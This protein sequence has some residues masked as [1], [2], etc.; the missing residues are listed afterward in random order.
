MQMKKINSIKFKNF[1]A[2]YDEATIQLDGKNLLVYGENGSGK[3]SIFWAL[4]TFLQ[5]SGKVQKDI[6]KYFVDFDDNNA[7]TFDSLKNIFATSAQD[8]FIELQTVNYVL[9]A[10]SGKYETGPIVTDRINALNTTTDR[11]KNNQAISLANASSDFINYKLLHNFYNVTHKQEINLWQVF[12]RDIF[13]LFRNNEKEKYYSERIED[14]IKTP[15]KSSG[16]AKN[17]KLGSRP[18]VAYVQRID[19]LNADIQNFLVEIEQNANVFLKTHFFDDEDVLR[20]FLTYNVKIDYNS[21]KYQDQAK[22]SISLDLELWDAISNSWRKVKRPHSFLNEAQLTRVAIA[23]RIGALQTRLQNREYQILCLDDML[24]SLDMGNRDKVIQ[25]FLNT[26]KQADLNFFDKFQKLIFT[27]DKAFYNLCKQRIRLSLDEKDW[28]FK[29]IYLDTD[30]V[31]HRPFIDNS[32]DYFQR[33]EKHSKA[34]D[35]P[36][37]ANALRQGLENLLFNFLPDND[38]L[39]LSQ[40]E[41]TTTGKQFNELL[42]R[43]KNIHKEYNVSTGIVD[44]LFVYKDHLL[45]PFSHDNLYT[46]VYKQEIESLLLIVPT[47][48]ILNS[49]LIKEAKDK[50]SIIKLID[51]N[52]A[53]E[54]IEYHIYLKENL[55][56]HTLLDGNKYLSKCEVIVLKEV[57][58]SGA[59]SPLNNVY[60]NLRKCAMRLATFLGKTYANDDEILAKLDLS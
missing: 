34:F 51:V 23:V 19:A 8:A 35:Y 16:S 39:Q 52:A 47:L 29:E 54:R 27:H 45:N 5:S 28:Y 33:A 11:A 13:P 55:K 30:K 17:L 1:K 59:E 50:N 24:I 57:K 60:P 12:S 20:V 58:P 43:L 42:D 2:F 48:K 37:A 14:L 40:T 10:G 3:S 4:Y 18:Q 7:D 6:F 46:Q 26:R 32:T 36:A 53:G 41:K 38:K 49:V 56:Q 21:I 15:P 9:N 31:P 44:D 22:Y 25:T